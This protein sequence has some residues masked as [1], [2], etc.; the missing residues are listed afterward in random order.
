MRRRQR[1][2]TPRSPRA[3]GGSSQ[4]ELHADFDDDVYWN[5]PTLGGR[6][7]P[8]AD[9]GNRSF[10][11]PKSEPLK[12]V[13]VADRSVAADNDLHD[14]FSCETAPPCVFGVVRFDFTNDA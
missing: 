1:R 4:P 5:A 9:G 3:A 6:E 10:V 13:D 11:E 7:F 2:P 12:Q 8:L 14:D